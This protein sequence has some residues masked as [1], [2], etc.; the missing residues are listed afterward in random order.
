MKLLADENISG[1]LVEELRARGIDVVWVKTHFRGISDD[2]VTDLASAEGRV[3]LTSDKGFGEQVFRGG[4]RVGVILLRLY[5]VG[6]DELAP[7]VARIVTS[8]EDWD[9]FFSVID[10]KRVRRIALP[11]H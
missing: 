10:S 5:D 1:V 11:I 3:I 4:R 9:L 6:P 7:M 2:V 8:H